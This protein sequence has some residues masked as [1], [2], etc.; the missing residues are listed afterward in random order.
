[1]GKSGEGKSSGEVIETSGGCEEMKR[2]EVK[3]EVNE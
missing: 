3:E 1:V 2:E